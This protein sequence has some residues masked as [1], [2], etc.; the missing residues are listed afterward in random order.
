MSAYGHAYMHTP[1]M[2]AL[3]DR[4]TLFSN[5]YVQVAV[6]MPSRTAFLSSRRPD[7]SMDWDIDPNQWP[8]ECGGNGCGGGE[9]GSGC[10]IRDI[11]FLPGWFLQHGY[12]TTGMGKIFHEGP[13]T[14]LQDYQHSWTPSTT[15]VVV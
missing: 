11:V 12:F 13:N 9:C 8:R 3:A 7:T 6:C 14:R 5:A 15:I 2:Q 10:G 4:S 1:H